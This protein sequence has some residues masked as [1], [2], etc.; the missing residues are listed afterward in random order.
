MEAQKIYAMKKISVLQI[1][2]KIQNR[3]LKELTDGQLKQVISMFNK[4]Q[5]AQKTPKY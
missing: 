3:I 2:L 4:S 1:N 5:K